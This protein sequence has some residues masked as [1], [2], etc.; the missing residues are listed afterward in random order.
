MPDGEGS[1][2]QSFLGLR[3]GDESAVRVVLEYYLDRLEAYA[4]RLLRSLGADRAVVDEQDLAHEAILMV[5]AG[6]RREKYK[7]LHDREALGRLLLTVTRRLALKRKRYQAA[8]RRTGRRRGWIGPA[9][10]AGPGERVPGS[11][12]P[13]RGVAV[14]WPHGPGPAAGIGRDCGT[15]EVIAH[16][17]G[18]ERTPDEVFGIRDEIRAVF[19]VL[20]DDRDREILRLK[21]EGYTH[22]EIAGRLDC[23]E[24]TVSL[25]FQRVC[26]TIRKL[27][28]A[29]GSEAPRRPRLEGSSYDR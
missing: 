26:L 17:A 25:R 23:S 19:D 11:E 6:F 4:R 8:G 12:A 21:L 1:I 10:P 27:A 7:D 28:D 15:E 13:G 18:R 5:V 3:T 20:E 22:L 24:R 9:E 14:A 29:H 2:T 16:V